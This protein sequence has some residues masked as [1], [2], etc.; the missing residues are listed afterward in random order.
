M[1]FV[2]DATAIRLREL[3]VHCRRPDTAAAPRV[4]LLA[5]LVI[6]AAVSR[7]CEV[8]SHVAKR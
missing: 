5:A 1:E 3:T 4:V 7:L 6:A 8:S 2:I